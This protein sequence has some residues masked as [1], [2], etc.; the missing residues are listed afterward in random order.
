MG[1]YGAGWFEQRGAYEMKRLYLVVG[2]LLVLLIAPLVLWQLQEKHEVPIAIID[3]TVVDTTYREHLGLTWVMNYGKFASSPPSVNYVGTKPVSKKE[4]VSSILP[5]NYDAYDMIYIADTYGV[6]DDDFSEREHKG[7]RSQKI[8][9]GMADKEWQTIVER[10]RQPKKSTLIAEY[11]SFASPTTQQVSDEMTAYLGVKWTGWI[12]RYFTELDYTKN[13]DIP[14]WVID[15]YGDTWSYKG[16]GFILVHDKKEQLIVL[17]Q[18]KEVKGKGIKVSTTKEGVKQF[19]FSK[20]ANYQYWFDIVTANYGTDTLATYDWQ[21]TKAGKQLLQDN[22]IPAEFAAITKRKREYNTSYY[23]A[24]D[25]NDMAKVPSFYKMKGLAKL[26]E[27]GTL[28]AEDSFYWRIYVPIM[29]KILATHVAYEPKPLTSQ[30]KQQSYVSE[31]GPYNARLKNNKFEVWR[32]N[33][34]EALTIKGVNIGM[35][36]PGYF[37]GEAAITE[38]EYYRWFKQIRAMNSNTIR[39]YTLQPPGFYRA[40]KHFNDGRKEP[41]YVMHGVWIEEAALADS[42]DAYGEPT[43][44][45]FKEEME[46]LVDVVHGNRYVPFITGHAHGMYDADVSQYITAWIIGI[47]W[48]QHM[49]VNT[50]K[51]YA[52]IG[53]YKGEFFETKGAAP[54]EYWL[55]E[56]MDTL[57][58]YQY[59]NYHWLT[60]MSFTNWVTTDILVHEDE[61]DKE[62]DIVGVNPNVI[63]TKGAMNGTGQFASYH[64]YPY[65]PDFFN[66]D[67]HY[68]NFID[69]RGETNSY[70]GYLRDLHE[71]HRMPILIAEFGVP[72]S[73]GKTHDNV[74]DFS[75]GFNS[76]QEQGEIIRH[77]FEDIMA[78]DLLGGLVFTWQDEWFKRTW[79][80]V[81]YDDPDRRPY[82]SNVQTNEQRFGL[83]AF[84]QH[85][86]EVDGQYDDW[87]NVKPLI[88][89][90]DATL[91]VQSDESFLYMKIK[92]KHKNPRIIVDTVPNQGNTKENDTGDTFPG[93]IE[94]IIKINQQGESRIVQDLYYD[95]FNFLY[96]KQ[97]DL[98][99]DRMPIAKKDTGQFSTIDYVLNKAYTLPKSKRELPFTWYETGKLREGNSNPK[100]KAFD[101]LADYYQQGDT[102]ELRIPWLLLGATDPSRKMFLGDFIVANE[103]VDVALEAINLGLYFEGQST[104]TK[105]T[106][107]TW[108]GWDLPQ[109]KERLKASYPIVK[110]LFGEYK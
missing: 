9:G 10:L 49:V 45:Q 96:A 88:K 79:N 82:W 12:G 7:R 4:Q 105:L 57:T 97:L 36:K 43:L 54:F 87:K 37:P 110:K 98:M 17:E 92:S 61:P 109:S 30:E 1:E 13:P 20:R 108:Q 27:A 44:S 89:T 84:D 41:L 69:H 66:Y 34:W 21:L 62:E 71:A 100:A 47:E 23:F 2:V 35:G 8:V 101:S 46:R 3:K 40:L 76:E 58:K 59:E 56:Q 50:N 104:P 33:K 67:E 74:Y 103:K 52:D 22:G 73:R 14:Q 53:Q 102:I 72:A 19:G 11:N 93:A 32:N 24:G 99:P 55:A 65:Y 6:Y 39:V 94:Y 106:P 28:F 77:L 78:E 18:D 90:E 80:T 63:Y 85:A 5:E 51:K 68:L 83:M 29:Q 91:H 38:E 26:Y 95:Y 81:D 107:Y 31:D 60:P 75:Q 25:Y 48:Y 42:L 64:V 70:A 16:A 15:Q 86:V